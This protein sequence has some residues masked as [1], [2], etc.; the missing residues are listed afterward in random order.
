MKS[1]K[2]KDLKESLKISLDES[3]KSWEE[4]KAERD[5][6]VA[7][8]KGATVVDAEDLAAEL[9]Q[10]PLPP[11]NKIKKRIKRHWRSGWSWKR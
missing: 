2:P 10:F 11:K 9:V 3:G 4:E 5:R 6:W 7:G 1:K 8:W